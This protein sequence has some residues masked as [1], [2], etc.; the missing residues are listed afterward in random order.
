M[1]YFVNNSCKRNDIP[2]WV[3]V[4]NNDLFSERKNNANGFNVT[5]QELKKAETHFT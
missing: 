2:S 1:C 5:E 4:F 3:C